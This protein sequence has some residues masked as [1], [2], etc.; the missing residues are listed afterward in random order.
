MNLSFLVFTLSR[1][2]NIV[3]W[4][5]W[6][7]LFDNI[8]FYNWLPTV[9]I[10]INTHNE[11]NLWNSN[12]DIVF[13]VSRW[14]DKSKLR[15]EISLLFWTKTCMLKFKTCFKISSWLKNRHLLK[16]FKYYYFCIRY[17]IP[18]VLVFSTLSFVLIKIWLMP[19]KNIINNK[20]TNI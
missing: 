20:L 8:D 4:I 12:T 15:I 5:S 9:K 13:I 19:G 2:F 17:A 7:K 3:W 11:K 6:R 16:N 18:G 14:E 10:C 1:Y